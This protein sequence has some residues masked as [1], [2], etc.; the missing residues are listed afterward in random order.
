MT[1]NFLFWGAWHGLGLFLHN[2]WAEF[3]KPRAAAITAHPTLS[4]TLNVLSI[5]FT[6]NYVALG[7]VWF[8]LPSLQ[9]S[10]RVFS[11]L[12]GGV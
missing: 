6:F 11:G 5:F 8:A 10:L 2:R 3:M 9:L 4:K 12:F 7:W 1:L